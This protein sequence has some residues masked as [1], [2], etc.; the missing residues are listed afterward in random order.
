MPIEST[1]VNASMQRNDSE[2]GG[3]VYKFQ[4]NKGFRLNGHAVIQC[5]EGQWNGSKPSCDPDG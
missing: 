2:D 1:P 5:H 4:C 3:M